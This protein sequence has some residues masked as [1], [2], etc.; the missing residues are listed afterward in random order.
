MFSGDKAMKRALAFGVVLS[1]FCGCSGSEPGPGAASGG[2]L[3][4][5]VAF[6][7]EWAVA[8]CNE[9]VVS[10]CGADSEE[11]CIE[12]QAAACID[13][14]P[15]GYDPKNAQ[16]CLDAV[17]DAYE[18]ADLTSEELELVLQLAAPCDQL[19]KGPVGEGE[20]C[21]ATTDCNTLEG[22]KC[23]IKS[24]DDNGTCEVPDEVQGGFSCK[25]ADEVCVEGFYCDGTNCLAQKALD[26]EC[27]FDTECAPSLLCEVPAGEQTGTCVE[28]KETG[29]D[30][31]VNEECQSHLCA[32]PREAATGICV[33]RV[34]LTAESA[35]CEDLR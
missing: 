16:A 28:R 25:G 31:S 13:L 32:K 12:S 26:D 33:N 21:D 10:A 34:R 27:A 19:I 1:W 30:C 17:A 6:C 5:T 3:K 20:V 22:L 4:T 8:A 9:E 29:D 7:N 11:S 35:F 2:S 23:I 24:G 15:F 14:I 18:D